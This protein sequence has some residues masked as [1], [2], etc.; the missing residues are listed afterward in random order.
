MCNHIGQI[1]LLPE[2]SRE[3]HQIYLAKGVLATTAI[4]GNTLSEEEVRKAIDGTLELPESR[5]Y[6]GKEV[7][8]III[9]FNKI[10]KDICSGNIAEIAPETLCE[11]NEQTLSGLTVEEGVVAGQFRQHLVTVGRYRCPH[12]QYVPELVRRLCGRLRS[13]DEDTKTLEPI[14]GAILK[15]IFAHLYVA[16]IHPFGDGN[17]RTARL[18]E[19]N[20][21]LR[22][23]VPSLAAHLLSNHY[24]ATRSEYYRM[25]DLASRGRDS[26][27][28][29]SYAIKGFRDGLREQRQ[30]IMTYVRDVVWANYVHAQFRGRWPS[31]MSKRQPDLVLELSRYGEPATLAEI[32]TITPT[33]RKLYGGMS[34]QTVRRDVKALLDMKLLLM[35]RVE[36]LEAYVP[37]RSLIDSLLPFS[38]EA[39]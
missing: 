28:F 17:G 3:L 26:L 1:P 36:R 20:I 35:I 11:Y 33:L 4:E 19:T 30:T 16:W 38:R 32:P 9:A 21:L 37:N 39:N 34:F 13:F 18:I 25:L 22:S 31:A 2:V 23:G 8:N 7:D 10:V 5:A 14:V 27:G 15:A 29:V 12:A 6:L 24:N